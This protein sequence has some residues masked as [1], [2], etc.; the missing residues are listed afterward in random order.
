MFVLYFVRKS[1]QRNR[2][3][4]KIVLLSSLLAMV[5]SAANADYRTVYTN[6]CD[7]AAMHALLSREAAAHRAVITEVICES[8]RVVATAAP[9][10][11]EPVYAPVAPVVPVVYE[12]ADNL[13]N[14][15]VVDCVPYPTTCEYCGGLR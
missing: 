13:S 2:N 3:M 5:V 8:T 14:I 6:N 4:K 9:V 15:P 1:K 10:V 12:S 7:P 11:Y